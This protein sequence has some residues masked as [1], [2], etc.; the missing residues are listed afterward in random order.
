M[1]L[2]PRIFSQPFLFFIMKVT[3]GQHKVKTTKNRYSNQNIKFQVFIS[4]S[5][6]QNLVVQSFQIK[7]YQIVIQT[8]GKQQKKCLPILLYSTKAQGRTI[9]CTAIKCIPKQLRQL[10]EK[11]QLGSQYENNFSSRR[12]TSHSTDSVA[13][14]ASMFVLRWLT[15][16]SQLNLKGKQNKWYVTLLTTAMDM[17]YITS[18]GINP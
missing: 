11:S 10:N 16:A 2:S 4:S 14:I 7:Q 12:L 1:V 3:G 18:Q 9:H 8:S 15:V 13:C 17:H 6:K 5:G